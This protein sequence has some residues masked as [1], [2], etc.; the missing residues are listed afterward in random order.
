MSELIG[1]ALG[2]LLGQLL[3]EV[4]GESAEQMLD[5]RALKRSLD[6]A[7]KRAEQRFAS[8]YRAQD[9]ELTDAL[10]TQT[11]FADLPSV[12][13]ALRE[14]LTRPF[15]DPTARVAALRRSFT[16][17]LPER[18][19]RAR[20]DAAVGAFLGYLGQEALYIPQL[21]QLYALS[22]QKT[23]AESSRRI[24]AS[25]EALV[26]GI[27]DL[28]AD[29]R[30]LPAMSTP[31]ALPAPAQPP[32]ER[33]RPWHNL[34]QRSYVHFVGR[35]PELEQLNR[36]LLPHPRSRHFLV[37]LDGI[38]GVGK[39]AL[40]IE[41]AYRYREGYTTL[42]A[43]ERFDAIV[44]VS[45]KRTLL[46]A[47]GIQQRQQ[48]FN[49]LADL[50]RE[51]AT[52]LEQPAILQA[53]AEQRRGLVERALAA[54][55]TLLIVDNLETVDDEELLTFLRE[56]PDPTKA[57]VTTR[58]RIDIAYAVRLA[59]MPEADA[60]ALMLVEAARKGVEL[61]LAAESSQPPEPA[62]G[63]PSVAVLDDLYR[64]T[65]GI[66]LAIVWS[67]A[68]M[69]MGYSVESV[70]R[71]LGSGHSDIARFCFTE[72]VARI[73]GRD[74]YKLL[75]ALA[76]FERSV[77]R[78]MLGQVAGLGDDTIGRDDGLAELLQLSLVEQ[79][80]DRF[81]LLP[82]TQSYA[83][84]ELA[85]QP[86]LE[87]KLRDRWVACL[88]E[89][90]L[91]YAEVYRRHRDLHRLLLEGVHLFTLAIW[92]QQVA[93]LDVLLKILPA[94]SMYYDMTGQWSDQISLGRIGLEYARLVGDHRS[95]VLIQIRTLVRV[96]SQQ[97]YVEE[98]E[99]HIIDALNVAKEMDDVAW[100]CAA[101]LRYSQFLRHR[102]A[103]EQALECC[104]Q[105]LQIL[106]ALSD[107]RQI[108]VQGYTHYE[109][110]K[111][112]RDRGDWHTAQTH[113]L[114]AQEVFST[115]DTDPA[116][117]TDPAFNMDLAWGVLS[118]LGFVAHQLGD[119]D[120]ASQIYRQCLDILRDIGSKA[121]VVTLLVRMASLEEQRANHAAALDYAREALEWSSKLGMVL[122]QAQAQAIVGRLNR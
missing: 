47:G 103:Y 36:L 53:D 72:S 26:Q 42:P 89:F 20:V 63:T 92:S 49:T 31:A 120:V 79:K 67:I 39:S 114:A 117:T 13:A 83:L 74:A 65:G 32:A 100:Q 55:R 28:R 25:A 104:Q 105:T 52:V 66:P 8:E 85:G 41:L 116:F 111:N 98:A 57:I 62:S 95:V 96:L 90:A 34:P 37:T 22:F 81:K 64:K 109:L 61:T 14:L 107:A 87:Q 88:S 71:R 44:W 113:L 21:Q 112:A 46:T 115:E 48:T 102:G 75:L 3:G 106:P 16:D 33:Q 54:Q 18:T 70:L 38:G 50:Y 93:R 77:N 58:H 56:L 23:S 119:L 15:H 27:G 5:K 17:V 99:N 108:Y 10:A 121:Y 12:Q 9:A 29:V 68:L 122:E 11:R 6:K 35:K 7:V 60:K 30:Q 69:S 19:D 2:Q 118:N 80:R 76:L 40:A 24:A 86:E 91:P 110:G 73:R 97:G 84:E 101:L 51:I 45:A 43:D 82:L 59:G 94:L 78:Q 1:N 4:F